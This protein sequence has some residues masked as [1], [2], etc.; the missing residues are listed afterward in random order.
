M[1]VGSVE[2]VV[3]FVK[4]HDLPSPLFSPYEWGGYIQWELYPEYKPFV[5]A[6]TLSYDCYKDYRDAT[7]GRKAKVFE[8]YKFNTV[9]FYLIPPTANQISSIIYSLLKDNDWNLLQVDD[10]TV[11][12]SRKGSGYNGAILDKQEYIV[13][14]KKEMEKK[15]NIDKLDDKPLID[16]A[17]LCYIQNDIDGAL[18]YFRK[19]LEVNGDNDFTKEWLKYL[20]SIKNKRLP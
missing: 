13:S 10:N 5:D 19:A 15:H 16:L 11:V 7:Q 1:A 4:D 9:I 2:R 6:R 8:K 14:L 18:L 3:T 12:F 20:N 17:Q